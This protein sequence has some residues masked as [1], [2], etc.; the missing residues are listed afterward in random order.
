MLRASVA[1]E[2]VR[3]LGAVLCPQRSI[4]QPLCG[5]S[6]PY[7]GL[8]FG[9]PPTSRERGLL[10]LWVDGAIREGGGASREGGVRILWV[11]EDLFITWRC[12]LLVWLFPEG[13]LCSLSGEFTSPSPQE[14]AGRLCE[15]LG[16]L[17]LSEP[18]S[19]PGTALLT[20]VFCKG[21]WDQCVELTCP[22]SQR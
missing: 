11:M 15:L 22:R 12:D 3:K 18:E 9:W 16:P 21:N 13:L 1:E 8:E 6:N 7:P 14:E 20:L 4:W 17:R 5:L 10:P 2:A 19:S